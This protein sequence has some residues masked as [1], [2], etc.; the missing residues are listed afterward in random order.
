[1]KTLHAASPEWDISLAC[2]QITPDT[3]HCSALRSHRQPVFMVA[4]C[5]LIHMSD[6]PPNYPWHW[7]AFC[8]GYK[9]NTKN[10]QLFPLMGESLNFTPKFSISMS[11]KSKCGFSFQGRKWH[12][13]PIRPLNQYSYKIARKKQFNIGM[14]SFISHVIIISKIYWTRECCWYCVPLHCNA[15]RCHLT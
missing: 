15:L 7:F 2:T 12:S 1:M 11:E 5:Y 8:F 4:F 9:R 3:W 14:S 6:H 13:V 10:E